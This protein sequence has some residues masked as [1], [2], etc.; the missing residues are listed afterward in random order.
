MPLQQLWEKMSAGDQYTQFF[1]ELAAEV[2]AGQCVGGVVRHGAGG[3]VSA[4]GFLRLPR[5]HF[6]LMHLL[7]GRWAGD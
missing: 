6:M 7:G 4:A 5:L 1:T 3:R 2:G